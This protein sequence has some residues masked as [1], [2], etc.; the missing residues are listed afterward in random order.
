MEKVKNELEEKT[1]E[2]VEERKENNI[3]IEIPSAF[4]PNIEEVED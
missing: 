1:N 4:F 2:T 3:M